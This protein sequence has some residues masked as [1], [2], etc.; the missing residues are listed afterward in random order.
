VGS[1]SGGAG[2]P[3]STVGSGAYHAHQEERSSSVISLTTVS[4]STTVGCAGAGSRAYSQC[5]VE[6]LASLGQPHATSTG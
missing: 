5:H 2:K 6:S 3:G 1:R 4:S